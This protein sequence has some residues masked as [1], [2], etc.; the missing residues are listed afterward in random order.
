MCLKN[1]SV[2]SRQI[3]DAILK[4]QR[5]HD[6]NYLRQIINNA[7][8]AA[9]I[10]D[11]LNGGGTSEPT[12]LY[13]L[14]TTNIDTTA[15]AP[16]KAIITNLEALVDAANGTRVSRGYLSDTK[17]SN[18]MKNVLLD[19][20]SGRFLFD[21]ADLEGYNYLQSTS[22]YQRKRNKFLNIFLFSKLVMK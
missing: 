12:G 22:R 9:I 16:T 2:P 11:F 14:I 17:L 13:S 7:Y 20:G 1:P 21:G 19:A 6:V 18:K 4:E 5:L 3:Y 15:T 10:T 8:G